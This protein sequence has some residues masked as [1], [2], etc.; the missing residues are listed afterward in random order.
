MALPFNTPKHH[1]LTYDVGA[2]NREFFEWVGGFDPGLGPGALGLSDEVLL[3]PPDP[4]QRRRHTVC[5]RGRRQ[6]PFR[7]QTTGARRLD[8]PAKTSGS[9]ECPYLSSLGPRISP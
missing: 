9:F 5:N 1:D 4:V 6:A 3:E 7:S 2:L 8:P